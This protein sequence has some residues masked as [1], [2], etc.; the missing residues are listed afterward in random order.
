MLDSEHR[1]LIGAVS[2]STVFIFLALSGVIFCHFSESKLEQAKLEAK[3]ALAKQVKISLE[4]EIEKVGASLFQ[5]QVVQ[6]SSFH[7]VTRGIVSHGW[8][9]S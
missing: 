2:H 8:D 4:F 3:E 5:G 6:I 7:D 1:G 9:N